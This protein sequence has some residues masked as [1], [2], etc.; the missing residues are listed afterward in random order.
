MCVWLFKR[1]MNFVWNPLYY[2]AISRVKAKVVVLVHWKVSICVE[3]QFYLKFPWASL[4]RL[5][6]NLLANMLLYV[7][8]QLN[9][10]W[11]AILFLIVLV[12]YKYAFRNAYL[13]S[14]IMKNV[15]M[16]SI[17]YEN[18]GRMQTKPLIFVLGWVKYTFHK[19]LC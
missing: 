19:A 9:R 7:Y 17:L 2:W 5:L 1:S 10:T 16:S 3:R 15:K 4:W 12:T 18:P 14:F 6:K 11:P 8:M 13:L